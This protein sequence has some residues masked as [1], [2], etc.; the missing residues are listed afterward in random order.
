MTSIERQLAANEKAKK[1]KENAELA[2]RCDAFLEAAG[3]KPL[4]SESKIDNIPTGA[5]RRHNTNGPSRTG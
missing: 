2:R 1:E 5:G 4:G 3:A